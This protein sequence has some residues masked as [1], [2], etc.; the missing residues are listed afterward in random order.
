MELP[1]ARETISP[2]ATAQAR[3]PNRRSRPPGHGAGEEAEPQH[4][5]AGPVEPGGIVSVLDP[6]P[7]PLERGDTDDGDPAEPDDGPAGGPGQPPPYHARP[8]AVG[9][10]SV[11]WVGCTVS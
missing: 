8:R 6:G 9:V 7:E 3:K 10:H 5:A 1:G 4:P 11:T 2:P